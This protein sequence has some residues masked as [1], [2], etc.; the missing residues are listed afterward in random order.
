MANGYNPMQANLGLM[1]GQQP[2]VST[3]SDIAARLSQQASQQLAEAQ[4]TTPVALG[5]GSA[6]SF[7]QQFQQQ[8]HQIQQQQSMGV[9]QAAMMAGTMPGAQQYAGGMLPSPLTMTPPS[10]GVFRPPAP[11]PSI[12][13]IAPMPIMPM[14]QTPFTPRLPQPMFRTAW[15]QEA[16]QREQ[17]ADQL[18]S[19]QAQ[20]PQALGQG[21]GIGLG[22]LAGGMLGG[23]FGPAGR[24]I[25]AVAGAGLAQ[26]TGAAPAMGEMAMMPM[27]PQ[28][29]QRQMGAALQS[30]SRDWVVSGPQL[31]PLGRGLAPEA[32]QQLAGG[33][34]RMAGDEGFQRETGNM[35][36]R[37]DLM[38]ITQMSGQ[39]GLMDMEQ[40]ISGIQSNLRR[41]SRVVSRFMQLTQ[42]PDVVNVVRQMGQLRQLGFDVNDME[43][44]AMNMRMFSRAAGTSVQGLQQQYG[45]PG[46]MTF[47][48]AGLAP[49]VGMNYGMFAGAAA[50][51]GVAG[52]TF[53]PMQQALFGGVQGIAQRNMQAQA[54]MLSMPLFGAGAGQY[55]PGGWG[56]N[57]GALNQMMGGQGGAQG[58]IM[59][60]VQNMGAAVQQGGVG[61]LAMFPLQQRMIQS[62]AAAAMSPFQ[63]NAMRFRSAQATGERLGLQ[64]AGAFAVGAQAMFGQ[65][66]AEQMMVEASD[67]VYW[68]NQR[69]MI[70]RRQEELARDQRQQIR[71]AAPGVFGQL[72]AAALPSDVT[73]KQWQDRMTGSFTRVTAPVGRAWDAFTEWRDRESA[74]EEGRMYRRTPEEFVAGTRREQRAQRT[75]EERATLR[76]FQRGGGGGGLGA[77]H[78]DYGQFG[79]DVYGELMRG[80][81]VEGGAARAMDAFAPLAG[82]VLDWATPVGIVG[83][84]G[85]FDSE[86]LIWN[87]VGAG[88][89]MAED[90]GTALGIEGAE[91]MTARYQGLAAKA[92]KREEP[93]RQMFRKARGISTTGKAAGN[94]YEQ[95]EKAFGLSAGEAFHVVGGSGARIAARAKE[96]ASIVDAWQTH[97][98]AGGMRNEIVKEIAARTGRSEEEV[99]EEFETL[100]TEVKDQMIA[101]ALGTASQTGDAAAKEAL[102]RT[103]ETVLGSEMA[104]VNALTAGEMERAQERMRKFEG[105]MGIPEGGESEAF[106]EFSK[107]ATGSDML[108]SALA[109]GGE[110]TTEQR[111]DLEKRSRQEFY[112][113][114]GLKDSPEARAQYRRAL[115]KVQR[116]YVGGEQV[117]EDIRERFGAMMQQEGMQAYGGRAAAAGLL[118]YQDVQ[119][120][121]IA[122][123]Q[124]RAGMEQIQG[125]TGGGVEVGRIGSLTELGEADLQKLTA[126][127]H[128]A[129]VKR[130]Q[131]ARGGGEQERLGLMR[132]LSRMGE[133][134]V[135]AEEEKT[136]RE[137]TG[138][139]ADKLR[140][141]KKAVGAAESEFAEVFKHFNVE[142]AQ[143]FKEGA[144]LL[145]E[146]GMEAWLRNK[147][148]A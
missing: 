7:G 75:W 120:G 116:G 119:R 93:T 114:K 140:E 130:I 57:Y 34:Q 73:M 77:E 13:P 117:S 40:G 53:S 122:M 59:N 74:R 125:I 15:E 138:A 21:A 17:R 100:P 65:E 79:R 113:E 106:R 63:M 18:F 16:M 139:E 107:R 83:A 132:A 98:T 104:R 4:H 136:I 64:G 60:A 32:A 61:A 94:I 81:G 71:D 86:D 44:A 115:Q 3:P 135:A 19:F 105:L 89:T 27:R 50:R 2:Q 56:V 85:G 31:H 9:Y 82:G 134:A 146:A 67:P 110:M 143:T 26:M 52:G 147:Q 69:Q 102:A 49:A 66:I 20:M 112:R 33:I 144:M 41:V 118:A 37:Q 25:G 62:Q 35:F 127:G 142:T 84:I 70:E 111:R 90:I 133:G 137:A 80:G 1:P 123:T 99:V 36:N 51:Q 148:Q 128:G 30:S 5:G 43:N 10:T 129:L 121:A 22:A 48:Q 23:R 131:A 11:P 8:L 88:L 68:R 72:A 96:G 47:Q 109:F 95:V 54:A 14:A 24:A 38:R 92:R 91:G 46:A 58:M 78:Y 145:K 87:R 141:S 124:M 42:E 28:I 6:F 29:E 97:I 108:M 101:M 76:Q 12:A 103:E 39:A 126:A 55:G 45:M